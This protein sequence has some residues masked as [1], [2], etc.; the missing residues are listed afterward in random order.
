MTNLCFCNFVVFIHEIPSINIIY[1]TIAIVINSIKYFMFVNPNFSTQSFMFNI[2]SSI[3]YSNYD[4]FLF[5]AT[6]FFYTTN[7]MNND[8]Q[9]ITQ[10]IKN[11]PETEKMQISEEKKCT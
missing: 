9:E 5:I 4:F 3:N 11:K 6:L 7:L 8:S 1:I 10:E 2:Y